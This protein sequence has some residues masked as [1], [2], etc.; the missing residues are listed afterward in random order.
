MVASV[1]L[2]PFPDERLRS[3]EGEIAKYE[4]LGGLLK[5]YCRQAV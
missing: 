3:T 5:F 4:R 2:E 1:D